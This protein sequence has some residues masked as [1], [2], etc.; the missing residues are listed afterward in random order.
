MAGMAEAVRAKGG[1]FLEA[2]VSGSKG[3][4]AAGQLIF[5][6][7]GSAPL[8]ERVTGELDLMGK[9]S[10]ILGGVGKGTEMKLVV[11]MIM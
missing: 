3:P 1:D 7:G 8:F 5:L 9:A 6:C 4:A 10:Y 2:P 11:N